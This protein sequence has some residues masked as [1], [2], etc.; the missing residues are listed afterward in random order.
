M[1]LVE[2]FVLPM[3]YETVELAAGLGMKP[4][5]ME[6]LLAKEPTEV[7]TTI[8]AVQAEAIDP[9]QNQLAW[10]QGFCKLRIETENISSL[11]QLLGI[12]AS[13]IQLNLEVPDTDLLVIPFRSLDGITWLGEYCQASQTLPGLEPDHQPPKN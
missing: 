1:G 8:R 6:A 4:K 12:R 11:L 5:E 2:H 7:Q 9:L 10:L 13:G 3:F